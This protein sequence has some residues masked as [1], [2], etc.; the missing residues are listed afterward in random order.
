MCVIVSHYP[1]YCS[2]WNPIEPRL[3]S[4]V[5]EAMEGVI[6]YD[7]QTVQKL[8]EQTPTSTGLTVVVRLNLKEYKTGIKIPKKLLSNQPIRYHPVIP[9]LNYR[10]YP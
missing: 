6:F 4:H 3:F 7:Y 5:Y 2:K 1:P 9:E 8:I 10:I